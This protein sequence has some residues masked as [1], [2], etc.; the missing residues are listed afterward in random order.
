M[1]KLL[2]L[3]ALLIAAM[4]IYLAITPSPIDPLAW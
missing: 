3:L 2:G 4:A 1:K